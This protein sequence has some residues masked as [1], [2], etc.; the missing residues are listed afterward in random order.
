MFF[1]YRENGIVTSVVDLT[2][3]NGNVLIEDFR[4]IQTD[5]TKWFF[6]PNHGTNAFPDSDNVRSIIDLDIDALNT[7]LGNSFD[8]STNAKQIV[9]AINEVYAMYKTYIQVFTT[10]EPSPVNLVGNPGDVAITPYGIYTMKFK[11]STGFV[12]ASTDSRFSG[13]WT[14][15]GVNKTHTISGLSSNFIDIGGTLRNTHW[16]LHESGNYALVW[17][18]YNANPSLPRAG[19]WFINYAATPNLDSGA[20]YSRGTSIA[21]DSPT[22]L[23]PSGSWELGFSITW[24]TYTGSEPSGMDWVLHYQLHT[25]QAKE[26]FIG[27]TQMAVVPMPPPMGAYTLKAVDGVLQWVT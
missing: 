26:L 10:D 23:P 25:T 21:P 4:P 9:N 12:A 20:I 2:D 22:T 8:L 24:S 6:G 11:V 27:D 19:Y 18:N 17:S 15:M 7:I 1:E 13:I 16:Y 5:G 14:D 3:T